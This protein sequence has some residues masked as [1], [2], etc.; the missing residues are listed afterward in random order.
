MDGGG[1][2]DGLTVGAYQ[3]TAD[4][5]LVVTSF[6]GVTQF[7]SDLQAVSASNVE[8]LTVR[9]S[10]ASFG[11]YVDASQCEAALLLMAAPLAHIGSSAF[12]VRRTISSAPL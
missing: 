8:N 1:G 7:Q 4:S 9:A 12:A 2:T 3:T 11:L 10:S 6:G 5:P